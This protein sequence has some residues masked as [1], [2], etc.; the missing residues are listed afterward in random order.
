M[1]GTEPARQPTGDPLLGHRPRLPDLAITAR[2]MPAVLLVDALATSA[3]RPTAVPG[4]R[5]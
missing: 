2:G 5:P 1:A 3:A 4:R